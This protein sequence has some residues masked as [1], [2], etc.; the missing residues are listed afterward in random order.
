MNRG[1]GPGH[2]WVNAGQKSGVSMM[3]GQGAA[4]AGPAGAPGAAVRP[5][6]AAAGVS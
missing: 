1:K 5:A 3:P 2:S 4:A 6:T